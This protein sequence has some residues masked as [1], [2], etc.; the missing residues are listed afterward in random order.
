LVGLALPADFSDALND[1]CA[2][3]AAT[4]CA[5]PAVDT[6]FNPRILLAGP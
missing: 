3:A 1:L 6:N 2:S 5:T 4:V